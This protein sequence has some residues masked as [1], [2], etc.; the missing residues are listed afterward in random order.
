MNTTK[1]SGAF[2]GTAVFF[3][4]AD[5]SRHDSEGPDAPNTCHASAVC[6]S[7]S[8]EAE[9]SACTTA[10]NDECCN[11]LSE[12]CSSGEPATCNAGC[13]RVLLP[14]QARCDEWLAADQSGLGAFV[15]PLLDAAAANCQAPPPPPTSCGGYTEFNELI[16]GSSALYSACCSDSSACTDGMPSG[17]CS[18]ACAAQVSTVHGACADFLA[19]SIGYVLMLMAARF[20]NMAIL[21]QPT[22]SEFKYVYGFHSYIHY[23]SY[24]K[25]RT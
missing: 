10:V 11:E 14:V 21:L 6:P 9:L 23:V 7:C 13:A 16:G 1:Q 18:D 8:S 25:R 12:D 17:S 19:G 5:G 22:L 24:R 2:G 3:V 15:K 20:H 4:D